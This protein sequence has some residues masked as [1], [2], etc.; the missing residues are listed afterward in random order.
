MVSRNSAIPTPGEII[1]VIPEAFPYSPTS[2]AWGLNPIAD[3][4]SALWDVSCIPAAVNGVPEDSPPTFELNLDGGSGTSCT[5]SVSAI[6]GT[7]V[8]L[9]S[10]ERC[11]LNAPPVVTS[12]LGWSTSPDFPVNVA[13]R[14][15]DMGWGAY[16]IFDSEGRLSSVFI[17]V[18]GATL[19]SSPG[20]LHA[21][22]SR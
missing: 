10:L 5:A 6:V 2:I 22:W 13:Q 7:W 14:Q 1:Y 21:I 12:F 18:G 15:V 3:G 9:P 8:T 4:R 16:E 20:T 17:P 11:T 19:I